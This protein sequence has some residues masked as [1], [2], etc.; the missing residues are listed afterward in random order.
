MDNKSL[1]NL[2]NLDKL[3]LHNT[4]TK[5]CICGTEMNIDEKTCVSCGTALPKTKLLNINKNTA[6]AKR[7]QSSN[8]AGVYSFQSFQLLSNGFE[9]YESEMLNF[10]IDTNKIEVKISNTKAFKAMGIN[11]EFSKYMEDFFPGFYN[12]VMSGLGEFRYDYAVSNFTSMSESQ[13]ANY[14]NIYWNYK[15][16]IPYLR[17]Y[18]VFYYGNKINLKKYFPTI[19]FNDETSIINSGI[20]L[21]LLLMWDIKN[22]KYIETIIDIS[23]KSSARDLEIIQD[24]VDTMIRA[25]SRGKY[26]LE[27]N[28]IIDAFSLLYNKEISLDDFIRIYN[29]TPED[30]FAQLYKFRQSYKKCINKVIDWSTID[31]LD[32]KTIGSLDCKESMMK[33]LK[34]T[35]SEIDDVY[36][37]LEKNPIEALKMVKNKKK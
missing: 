36:A 37:M 12:Y 27:Y 24:I 28:D 25:A 1:I 8:N 29:N 33:E 11:T 3:G 20:C 9:L 34:I 18:K 10:S 17:K 15:A 23:N 6:I 13:I 21:K 22:E 2:Y 16:L 26:S 14:F 7:Y 19:D 32:R 5:K 35:K 31:K 4:L 30:Y